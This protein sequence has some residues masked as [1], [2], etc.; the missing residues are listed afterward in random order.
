MEDIREQVTSIMDSCVARVFRRDEAEIAANHELRFKEDLGATS[1]QYFP[2]IS[3]FEDKLGLYLDYHEFQFA[4][5]TI[6]KA[7][8]YTVDEYH[9]QM[10]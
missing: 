1:Q 8:D 4:A 10:E 6:Q 5:T 7:I 9:K 2:I 3:A